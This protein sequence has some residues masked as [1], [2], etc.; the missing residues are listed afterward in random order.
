MAFFSIAQRRLVVSAVLGMNLFLVISWLSSSCGTPHSAL[1]QALPST[2]FWDSFGK[3]EV[4][5]LT[6]PLT[7]NRWRHLRDVISTGPWPATLIEG[8]TPQTPVVAEALVGRDL[9]E[10]AVALVCSHYRAIED[11]KKKDLGS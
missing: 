1:P 3:T 6:I 9:Q 8:C 7:L 11:A 4:Y 10:K 5:V 2:S